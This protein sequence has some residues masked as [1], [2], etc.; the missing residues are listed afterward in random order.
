M[1]RIA[2]LPALNLVH[3][4]VLWQTARNGSPSGVISILNPG[5]IASL[6]RHTTHSPIFSAARWKDW[7]KAKAPSRPSR[8]KQAPRSFSAGFENGR[9]NA[10]LM[11]KI[12][13]ERMVSGRTPANSSGFTFRL[14]IVI[15]GHGFVASSCRYLQGAAET[16]KGIRACGEGIPAH[17][18]RTS[19]GG[20]ER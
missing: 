19:R 9:L 4:V 13:F 16:A 14:R 1:E 6:P 15:M 18:D 11:S 12:T 8:R 10:N 20:P 3:N 5:A 2:R 7:A 17:A